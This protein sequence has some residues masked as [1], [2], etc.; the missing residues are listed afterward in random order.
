M[1]LSSLHMLTID[2]KALDKHM[3]PL[4][5]Y[6]S[7]VTNQKITAKHGQVQLTTINSRTAKLY[8]DKYLHREG[9]HHYRV[10]VDRPGLIRVLEPL[11]KKKIVFERQ[12]SVAAPLTIP[13]YQLA[14]ETSGLVPKPGIRKWKQAKR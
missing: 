6:L 1:L 13:Q 5:Q 2:L 9:L 4:A 14:A 10:V 3:R 11:V 7:I 12:R 8:L